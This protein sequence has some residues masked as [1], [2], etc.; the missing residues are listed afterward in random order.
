M[1]A[2]DDGETSQAV[3]PD[4]TFLLNLSNAANASISDN[5]G[6]VRITVAKWLTPKNRTID[7]IGLT[8]DVVAELT[9]ADFDAKRDPQLDAAVK[10]LL[11]MVK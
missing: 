6:A 7:K 9:K 11:D 10:T 3:E 2:A 8:P 1:P 5:Q 4:E